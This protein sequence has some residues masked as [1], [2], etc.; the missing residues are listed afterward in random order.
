MYEKLKNGKTRRRCRICRNLRNN[1]SHI[2]SDQIIIGGTL[3]ADQTT[4]DKSGLTIEDRITLI[5]WDKALDLIDTKCKDDPGP[6]VDWDADAEDVSQVPS[7]DFAESLCKGCPLRE[8][9]G[10]SAEI[11]RPAWGVRDGR[12]YIFGN[13]FTE[14]S[15]DNR[16]S[17]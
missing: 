15:Y 5:K 16:N 17:N 14:G 10:A 7:P 3:L 2:N 4:Y 8:L 9:C 6:F 13:E 11:V 1:K 12:V